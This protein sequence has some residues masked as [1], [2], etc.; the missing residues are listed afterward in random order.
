VA[1]KLAVEPI[2]TFFLVVT[3]GQTVLGVSPSAAAFN[4]APLA[5]GSVLM[6]MVY[7]GGRRSGA[8]YNPGFFFGV[9]GQA[10]LRPSHRGHRPVRPQ[11]VQPATFG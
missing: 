3:V 10:R 5:I 9:P 6:V 8:R 1:R 11:R 2:G 4:L 7:A